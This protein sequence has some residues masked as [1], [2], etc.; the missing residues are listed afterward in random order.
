MPD[1]HFCYLVDFESGVLVAEGEMTFGEAELL[2]NAFYSHL[3]VQVYVADDF[4]P[5]FCG[6]CRYCCGSGDVR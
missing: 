3:N 2:V 5:C 4:N 6:A 1:L